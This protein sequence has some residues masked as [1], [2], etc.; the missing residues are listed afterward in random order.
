MASAQTPMLDLGTYPLRAIADMFTFD[1]ATTFATTS[2]RP[3]GPIT[4]E[5]PPL[6]DV[7]SPPGYRG[8]WRDPEAAT[9]RCRPPHGTLSRRTQPHLNLSS[10]L[11]NRRPGRQ[12]DVR[13]FAQ[14]ARLAGRGPG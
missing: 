6:D 9:H 7:Q 13:L 14:A 1:M 11:L 4:R 10:L 5:L 3:R 12:R 2:S 8:Y